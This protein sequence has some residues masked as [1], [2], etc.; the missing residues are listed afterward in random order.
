MLRQDAARGDHPRADRPTGVTSV[1]S[2]SATALACALVTACCLLLPSA[3]RA[4]VLDPRN[5]HSVTLNNGLRVIVCEDEAAPVVSAEIVVKVGSADES[6]EESGIAH[7]L[8]HVCW[9]GDQQN[10]PRAAIEDMGG[11]TNAGTLR[12]FTR[13]YAT[14]Q[15]SGLIPALRALAAMVLRGSFDEGVISRERAVIQ[16]EVATRADRPRAALN[17]LAFESLFGS[18]HPYARHIEGTEQSLAS[19]TSARL[20]LFHRTWYVPNNMAV[21]VGGDVRFDAVVKEVERRFG[22][23]A[24]EAV[25]ARAASPGAGSAAARERVVAAPLQDAYLITAF[26]SPA[27]SDPATVCANDVAATILG[28]PQVGRLVKQLQGERRLVK[29]TGVDFL[30]QRAPGLFGVW[31]VCDPD[32]IEEARAAIKA[33]LGRLASE[34]VS[35]GELTTAKRL[36]A[37]EYAFSNET[38]AE[39]VATLGFYE[40]IDSYRLAAEYLPLLRSVT[41]ADI[42]RAA[43]SYAGEPFW[44]IM[45]PG[46]EQ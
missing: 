35:P 31:A 7:L 16:E 44:I 1:R 9:V 46:S 43:G 30:T 10:D 34:P 25:P 23:L 45:R 15:P 6:P 17:D 28:N 18:A 38:A 4:E 27:V 5:I 36:L 13:Y 8:E 2:V 20:A 12:D 41:A 22:S 3:I 24:P 19:I 40:A 11:A 26:A 42:A 29:A 14:V 21:I 39:R 33:E 32:K 37:A